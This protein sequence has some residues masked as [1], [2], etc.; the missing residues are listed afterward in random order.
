MLETAELTLANMEH[1]TERQ[2][3]ASIVSVKT[4]LVESFHIQHFLELDGCLWALSRSFL[5]YLFVGFRFFFKETFYMCLG[6]KLLLLH[7]K[8][9]ACP[10]TP[11]PSSIL[12]YILYDFATDF[13]DL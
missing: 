9:G 1:R 3:K 12:T 8:F 13:N 11:L 2:C 5:G 10:L 4:H 6:D 7:T